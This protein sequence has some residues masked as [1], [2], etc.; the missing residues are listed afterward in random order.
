MITGKTDIILKVRVKGIDELSNFVL[1][2]LRNVEGIANT[3]TMII[4]N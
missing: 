1:R 4:F 2:E 3:E